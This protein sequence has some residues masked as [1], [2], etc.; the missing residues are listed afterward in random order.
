MGRMHPQAQKSSQD[1]SGH[2]QVSGLQSK[3]VDIFRKA[4]GP[5]IWKD[6]KHLFKGT[7]YL[8]IQDTGGQ[9]EFMDM[10]PALTIGPALYLLFCKLID[11]LK[12][13]YTVSYLSPSGKS[14]TPKKSIYTMEEVLLTAL[15]SISCYSSTQG[16]TMASSDAKEAF[17]SCKSSLAYIVGTHKDKVSEEQIDEFDKKLQQ[18]IRST[19][20]F[21]KGLVKFSS[22]NRMVLPIDNMNGGKSEIKKVQKFLE[23]AMKQHFKKLRIPA[24]WFVLS[25]C[26]REKEKRTATLQSVLQLAGELGMPEQE[27]KLALWFL[28]HYAGVLMYFPKLK[29]LKDTVICDTQVVYDS[30]TNLIINTFKFGQVDQAVLEWFRETGQFSLEDIKRSTE[31]VSGDYI[32]LPKLVKLLEHLNIIAP[33][34][35]SNP[36]PSRTTFSPISPQDKS[37][38]MPCVLQN[39]PHQE[40][41]EWWAVASNPL[42]APLFIRY[43]C[44]FIPIGV[45]PAMI[46]NLAG[47]ESLL[48]IN[49]DGIKKNRVEFQFG[50]EYD[51]VTL[52]SHPKYYAVHLS[53]ES[54]AEI[55]IHEVCSRVRELIESTLKT[56]TSCMNYSFDAEYQLAFECPTHPGREHL[57]IVESATPKAML[58]LG[59]PKNRKPK[60]MQS[61]HL[62]WFSKVN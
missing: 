35:Q 34:V 58:C 5:K 36:T 17:T 54:Y 24:A 16:E 53:Q 27:T 1:G 52:I 12:S 18:S 43:K 10:L 48:H 7:A 41:D 19:D 37:Y 62:V 3:V 6:V 9:P 39:V 21:V 46:A 50:T 15:S 40:L 28:H 55:P 42:I 26:L 31:N 2:N 14:T 47:Q 49:Y 56:V 59:N 30:A 57:C 51:T 20:F 22:E 44:G 25:L 38:F 13:H 29:E 32:P 23:E 11:D 33:I 8:K 60:K 4:A 61:Q 45:F